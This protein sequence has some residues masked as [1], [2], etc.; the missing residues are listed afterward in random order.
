[1]TPGISPVSPLSP[2]L[3][4]VASAYNAEDTVGATVASVLAQTVRD[5]ELIVVDDGSE[6]GTVALLDRFDDPRLKVI[7]NRHTGLPAVGFNLAAQAGTAPVV[8]MIGADDRWE[9]EMA[10]A[11]L[12]A[13][14]RFPEAG[15]AHTHAHHWIDGELLPQ[16]VRHPFGALAQAD[17][18]LPRMVERNFIYAPSA[19][20]RRSA[21]ETVGGFG[22]DS[23]LRGTEDRDLWL[24]LAEAG[25]AFAF[26]ERPL[27]HYRILPGSLSRNREANLTGRIGALERALER[28]PERYRVID[29]L[30]REQLA[31]LYRNRG[32][33]RAAA[34]QRAAALSDLAAARQHRP[35]QPKTLLWSLA[36][37]L[38]AGVSRRL[39]HLRGD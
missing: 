16:P 11:L 8:A 12:E 29:A 6:D 25:F 33:L 37:R 24:R 20:I 31:S 35:W 10:A 4:V 17:A 7:P 5:L 21:L 38:G 32:A 15:M 26:V 34:G 13:F 2:R 39:L 23:R 14:E 19:A 36:T 22:E 9:P 18:V 30:V 3:T 1:M 27:L 28:A